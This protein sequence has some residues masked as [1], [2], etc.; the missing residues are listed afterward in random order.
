MDKPEYPTCKW[1]NYNGMD[2]LKYELPLESSEPLLDLT[3]EVWYCS[4]I[5]SAFTS[6]D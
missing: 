1:Q 6:E 4:E 2:N 5:E 3:V